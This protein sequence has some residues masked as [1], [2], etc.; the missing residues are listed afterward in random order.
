MVTSFM[1]VSFTCS[2]NTVYRTFFDTVSCSRSSIWKYSIHQMTLPLLW[3]YFVDWVCTINLV[4]IRVSLHEKKLESCQY[5]RFL[6]KFT[7]RTNKYSVTSWQQTLN[8]NAWLRSSASK[9]Y[10]RNSSA[11]CWRREANS[12]WPLPISSRNASG[13]T[14]FRCSGH[15]SVIGCND[16]HLL[17]NYIK[18]ENKVMGR[19]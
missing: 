8:S 7:L 12:W 13:R 11:S 18:V 6:S 14:P 15:E 16:A 10:L 19:K 1:Y 2:S 17:T 5:N 3:P 9:K 4:N